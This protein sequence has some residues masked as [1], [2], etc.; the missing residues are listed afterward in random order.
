M[1]V[2]ALKMPF[3]SNV[4]SG[5]ALRKIKGALLTPYETAGLQERLDKMEMA[6]G[7]CGKDLQEREGVS[8]VSNGSGGHTIFCYS[9]APPETIKCP[10]CGTNILFGDRFAHRKKYSECADHRFKIKDEAP[11]EA[12]PFPHP[13]EDERP[14]VN[15]GQRVVLRRPDPNVGRFI[16]AADPGNG[17]ERA[18]G[19][20]PAAPRGIDPINRIERIVRMNQEEQHRQAEAGRINWRDMVPRGV[21]D[22]QFHVGIMPPPPGIVMDNLP[23]NDPIGEAQPEIQEAPEYFDEDGPIDRV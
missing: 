23:P 18:A 1:L 14:P 17:P 13:N 4:L 20:A 6:C 10:S 21:A 16:Y 2:S 15:V 7:S 19:P 8:I 5:P 12:P 22:Q 11:M 3:H 9:C